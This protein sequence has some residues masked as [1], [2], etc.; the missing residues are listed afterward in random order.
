MT[1]VVS[2]DDQNGLA[3]LPGETATALSAHGLESSPSQDVISNP[4]GKHIEEDVLSHSS[5]GP[6]KNI[7]IKHAVPRDGEGEGANLSSETKAKGSGGFLLSSKNSVSKPTRKFLSR[8]RKEDKPDKGKRKAEGIESDIRHSKR[9]AD[10]ETEWQ[11]PLSHSPLASEIIRDGEERA[12][13]DSMDGTSAS[14]ARSSRYSEDSR[15][16]N[17]RP[18]SSSVQSNQNVVPPPVVGFDTDPAQIVS[19]ALSLSEGRRRQVSGLRLVSTELTGA[20]ARGAGML[21]ISPQSHT[22]GSLAQ[23]MPSER[24]FSRN[25]SPGQII[26]PRSRAATIGQKPTPQLDT[27]KQP[28]ETVDD[29]QIEVSDPTW[30]RAQ[31]AKIQF[32]LHYE[33]RRVLSHLPPLRTPGQ[34]DSGNGSAL[35]AVEGRVYNPLQYARNRKLRFREKSILHPEEDGW[36]DIEKVRAWVE[37]VVS[38]HKTTL[39]DPDECVRLPELGQNGSPERRAD[40]PQQVLTGTSAMKKTTD[41]RSGQQRRPRSDWVVSPGDL[42]ADTHWLERGTNKA[43]I[44]DRDGNRLY[45]PNTH[46]KFSG[47]SRR[48]LGDDIIGQRPPMLGPSDSDGP[49]EVL[50][51]NHESHTPGSPDFRSNSR[52][53]KSRGRGR[54]REYLRKSIIAL[55]DSESDSSIRGEGL[56]KKGNYRRNQS[57]LHGGSSE[58]SSSRG[59]RSYNAAASNKPVFLQPVFGQSSETSRQRNHHPKTPSLSDASVRSRSHSPSGS[60]TKS[61]AKANGSVRVAGQHQGHASTDSGRPSFESRRIVSADYDTTAPNSPSVPGFP[62]IAINLSPPQSRSPS[63]SKKPSRIHFFRDRSQS[64]QRNGISTADFADMP[65]PGNSRRQSTDQAYRSG[66]VPG[67]RGTSPT[68]KPRSITQSEEA[69]V[70]GSELHRQSTASSKLSGKGS[71]NEPHKIRGIFKGGRIA[72]LVGNEVNRAGAFIWKKEPPGYQHAHKTS[73]TP[74]FNSAH[75]DESDQGSPF[76]NG[77]IKAPPK[78]FGNN[79]Q[80]ADSSRSGQYLSPS[81]GRP[82]N[83]SNRP[84]FQDI[85]F[86][87]FTSPFQRDR[88]MQQEREKTIQTPGSAS[89]LDPISAQVSQQSSQSKSKR[90]DRLAPPKLDT[91]QSGGNSPISGNL[92]RR[93]SYGFG[94]MLGMSRADRSEENVTNS[95]GFPVTGLA[96]LKASTSNLQLR[97]ERSAQRA[98]TVENTEELAITHREIARARALVMSSGVKAREITRRA[99]EVRDPVPVFLLE[100]VAAEDRGQLYVPRKEEHVVAARNTINL[101]ED[102]ATSFRTKFEDFSNQTA[103]NLHRELQALDDLVENELTPRV[104]KAVDETG[105]LSMKLT[106]TSTLATKDLNEAINAAFRRRRRGPIRALRRFG[107]TLIEWSVVAL[108]WGIWLFVVIFRVFTGMARGIWRVFRWLVWA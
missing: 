77:S 22:V 74:S 19:L 2:S 84:I 3:T 99:N 97:R 85:N 70:G 55:H 66:S 50:D 108:L 64:K 45:P 23:F 65:S 21:A 106:T 71:L 42:L 61:T 37:A 8:Y 29:A 12:P 4:S 73:S 5:K 62:S 80:S 11:Q 105:E 20:G 107:Y 15:L 81:E 57:S 31:K 78:Q 39:N 82:S 1:Q 75:T 24:R 89:Y 102:S 69:F 33:F 14:N 67:S 93:D 60:V 10:H 98:R 30:A 6:M 48:T 40:D 72:E 58:Q 86:P 83:E 17:T 38:N 59:R 7:I 88:E 34:A 54:R 87:S 41:A 68:S 43:K 16:H 9:R 47:W 53:R 32:E 103:P 36:T 100:T 63:P 25:V 44:E 28:N 51:R 104:R 49:E 91:G 13:T 79:F 92:E 76:G 52:G 96:G 27:E 26:N 95:A 35:A 56:E 90:F 18:N 94:N 46:F 101:L